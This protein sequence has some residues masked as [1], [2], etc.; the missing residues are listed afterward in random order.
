MLENISS[1]NPAPSS[2][3]AH[4]FFV[5]SGVVKIGNISESGEEV[6]F[7]IRKDG[8]VVGELSASSSLHID[9]ILDI[10]QKN[11]PL[12]RELIQLFCDSLLNAHEQVTSLAF[13]DTMQRLTHPL[14]ISFF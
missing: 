7:D 12:L 6:I 9:E 1:L 5:R 13:R 11:E 3:K 14:L 4:S 8:E 2:T 10:I